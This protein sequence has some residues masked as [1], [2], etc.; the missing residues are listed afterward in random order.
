M[1]DN[2]YHGI[3]IIKSSVNIM[4]QMFQI[5]YEIFKPIL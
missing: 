4:D 2:Y 1:S 3:R 5:M